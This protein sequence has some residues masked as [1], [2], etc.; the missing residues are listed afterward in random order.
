MIYGVAVNDLPD[1]KTQ[2]V[3]KHINSFGKVTRKVVWQCPF[4]TKWFNMLSRCYKKSELT[5]HPTYENKTVCEEWLKFSNFKKWMEQQDW[6]NK[7]LDK[8]ILF[9]GN[10]IYSPSTCVFV[11]KEINKFILEKTKIRDFPIGVSFH[12]KKS[13][14]IASISLGRN[15][16]IQHLGTFDNQYEAHLY[17]AERKLSLVIELVKSEDERVANA[18][19][20]RYTSMYYNA[21]RRYEEFINGEK[22]V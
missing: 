19:V 15:G 12:K 11:S 3:E 4:Y 1:H 5:R 6:E 22:L 18:L 17:W 13:K 9:S 10:S 16:K 7:E 21:K 14:F 2:I 20:D 8:D